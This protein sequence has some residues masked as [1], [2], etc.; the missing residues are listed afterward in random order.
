ME[1]SGPYDYETNLL[2]ALF[3]MNVGRTTDAHVHV[4]RAM[5]AEPLLL[6]PVTFM[7]AVH[8]MRVL[9]MVSSRSLDDA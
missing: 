3:L 5:R 2:Y 7:A 1:V 9:C 6:R 4:E 8:E